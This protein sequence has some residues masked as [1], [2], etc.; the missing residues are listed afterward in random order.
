MTDDKK[1]LAIEVVRREG[2]KFVA[3]LPSSAVLARA[4]YSVV[5]AEPSHPALVLGGPPTNEAAPP[6]S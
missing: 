1:D 2:M 5:V 6:R 4:G 3:T